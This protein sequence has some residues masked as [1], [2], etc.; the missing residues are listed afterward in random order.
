METIRESF[1]WQ[2]LAIEALYTPSYSE[3]YRSAYGYALAHLQVSTVGRAPLPISQTGYLSHFERADNIAVAGGA[4]AYVRTWL[5]Y[6]AQ[7]PAWLSAQEEA[8]Q[9]S[10]L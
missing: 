7:S 1:T 5:E 10:L 9:L 2:G 6:A 3:A 4:I 8:R